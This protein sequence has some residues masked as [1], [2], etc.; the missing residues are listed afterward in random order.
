VPLVGA[1]RERA[2]E[3]EPHARIDCG[4]RIDLHLEDLREHRGRRR[5]GEGIVARD[6]LV[7][8]DGHAEEVAPSVELAGADLLG[9]HELRRADRV[10]GLRL[11]RRSLR[12]GD[13]EIE[14][15]GRD[16]SVG[17]D[18]EED[19]RRLEVAMGDPELVR[20]LQRGE[21]RQ[22]DRD[23]LARRE[24]LL[25]LVVRVERL[26]AEELEHEDERAV[27][28]VDEIEHARDAPVVQGRAEPRLVPEPR[29]GL[30]VGAPL[31]GEDLQGDLAARRRVA[32]RPYRRHPARADDVEELELPPYPRSTHEIGRHGGRHRGELTF[33]LRTSRR[34]AADDGPGPCAADLAGGAR[35]LLLAYRAVVRVAAD[36][37]D[38]PAA[39]AA[40][41]SR[42]AA[43]R[44]GG[45]GAA[46]AGAAVGSAAVTRAAVVARVARRASV[47]VHEA[48][49][50]DRA[51]R[52]PDG[53][54]REEERPAGQGAQ[55][56]E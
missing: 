6:D 26:A 20:V 28:A 17:I 27:L 56:T 33:D 43:A 1:L 48:D 39:G 36:A 46:A 54:E 19:V 8:D 9:R 40:G 10:A 47:L 18:V 4:I 52:R 24:R 22:H 55:S 25:A 5:A 37:P 38:L 14:Q 35:G 31:G 32:R 16:L 49:L 29:D 41:R 23:R 45:V 7:E 34:L 2:P 42:A 12:L 44:G 15:L 30:H 13:A 53:P 50:R 3:L 51:A 11:D 21:E